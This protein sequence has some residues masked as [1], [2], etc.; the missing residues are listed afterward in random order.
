MVRKKFTATRNVKGRTYQYFRRNGKFTRLP[1]N[2]E[3]EEYD[4]AYWTLMR[5]KGPNN[6]QFTFDKLIES[7]RASPKW[8][9]LAN[10]TKQDYQKVLTYIHEIVGDKDPKK[11]RRSHVIDAQLA[12]KHR[13]RFA[14]YVSQIM[15]ILF[16]HAIDLDR[17]EYNPARGVE[18][19]K[20]GDGH[21][22]WPELLIEHF[23]EAADPTMRLLIELAIGTGQRIGDILEMKWSDIEGDEIHVVQNKTGTELWIP[24]T[25]R[26]QTVLDQT[27]KKGFFILTNSRGQKLTYD[28]AE[29]RFRVVRKTIKGEG[30]TIHGLRYFA[31]H[32][33]AEA[34]CN[35]AQIA[36]IT[37]HKSVAMI[38]RYSRKANQRIL[39]RLAQEKRK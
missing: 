25:P 33:L 8:E 37:G 22:P 38:A 28:A 27:Q 34:G 12:N 4:R 6:A 11:M 14:N 39:A 5:G 31:A 24:F 18:K 2:P 17:M 9:K 10:R 36:S 16:E 35:D 29:S 7:Y 3:S 20:L 1:D 30:Y 13:A 26:L 32:Q 21:K 15:S 19:I 23:L